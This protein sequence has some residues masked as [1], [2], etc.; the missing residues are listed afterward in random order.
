MKKLLAVILIMGLILPAAALAEDP[1]PIVG[2]WYLLY[3][4]SLFPEMASTFNGSD[5]AISVYWFMENGTI[6]S[7]E[8]SIT[9]TSGA[10]SF[11]TAGRW[12][13]SVDSYNYGVIGLGE[14]TALVEDDKILLSL[15]GSDGYYMVMHRMIPFDP[16]HD[17]LMR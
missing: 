7:T 6:M 12:S 8:N 10:P 13:K 11:I 5:I 17:Y 2:S 4:K 3:D 9:G 1:D 14:G 16:Y 15:P